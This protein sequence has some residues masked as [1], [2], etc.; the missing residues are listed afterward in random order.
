MTFVISATIVRSGGP[1][2]ILSGLWGLFGLIRE[3]EVPD[4]DLMWSLLH[5]WKGEEYLQLRVVSYMHSCA[6]W[7]WSATIM[8][9]ID[10]Q[11][12]FWQNHCYSCTCQL[13][14]LQVQV[15]EYEVHCSS[16]SLAHIGSLCSGRWWWAAL[17]IFLPSLLPSLLQSFQNAMWTLGTALAWYADVHVE[18]Y[19]D[20]CHKIAGH[21]L[22]V[23][24]DLV[25]I[26]AQS[27]A[28]ANDCSQTKYVLGLAHSIE[29]ESTCL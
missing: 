25:I 1:I 14:G 21:W 2:A 22:Q 13:R 18:D 19:S 8:R 28:H 20:T 4:G 29:F 16:F 3:L 9:R 24:L 12:E 7:F 5:S 6:V 11:V 15:G 17:L 10:C 27:N 26:Q 23:L